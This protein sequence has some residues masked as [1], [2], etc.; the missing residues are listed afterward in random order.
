MLTKTKLN[1]AKNEAKVFLKKH[2][3]MGKKSPIY[4]YS[5]YLLRND[6]FKINYK[7]SLEKLNNINVKYNS[8]NIS[9]AETDTFE[10]DL[11]TQYDYTDNMLKNILIHEI[12][13][14][15][16]FRQD[17]HCLPEHK[18]HNLMEYINPELITLKN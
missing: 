13:H 6:S 7:M 9:Y 1:K 11:N 10:I 8:K 4:K 12:L 3:K 2:Q 16:V 14:Y 17:K 5:K 15:L 18:E